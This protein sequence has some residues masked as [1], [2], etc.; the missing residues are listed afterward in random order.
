MEWVDFLETMRAPTVMA[1][2]LEYEVDY[3]EQICWQDGT[4][5][6]NGEPYE[7]CYPDTH[8]YCVETRASRAWDAFVQGVKDSA[9]SNGYDAQEVDEWAER[10]SAEW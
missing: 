10:S 8:Y 2:C 4:Y 9:V 5:L 7:Y 3:V 6:E 1:K